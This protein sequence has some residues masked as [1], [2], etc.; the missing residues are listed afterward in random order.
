[1][2][3]AAFSFFPHPPSQLSPS[4]ES[5]KCE[6]SL[7]L[8]VLST[9]SSLSSCLPRAPSS[10]V[11][12]GFGTPHD[13]I[14]SF[15]VLCRFQSVSSPK[16]SCRVAASLGCRAV[17]S[18]VRIFRF[19]FPPFSPPFDHLSIVIP[20]FPETRDS[21]DGRTR[22]FALF[23]LWSPPPPLKVFLIAPSRLRMYPFFLRRR[24][25]PIFPCCERGSLFPQIPPPPP[26][27]Y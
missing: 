1:L 21:F 6:P 14:E 3:F 11:S 27:L 19:S 17:N 2:T 9:S 12:P 26:F 8:Q 22:P 5:L 15:S 16:L 24:T 25:G 10:H 13:H 23:Y 20:F 18:F 4:K 7:F